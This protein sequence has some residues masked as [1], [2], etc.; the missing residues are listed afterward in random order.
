M[1]YSRRK[2]RQLV[3]G[4]VGIGSNSEVSVQSMTT[5]KTRNTDKTLEQIY[6]LAANGADIVRVTCNEIE[7]AESLVKICTRSPVPIVADIHFQYKLAL[8]AIEAGVQGLRLNPGNIRNEDQIKQ[9]AK[10]CLSAD[11][12]IR[13]GV[14]A[15]SLD[16]DLLEKFGDATPEALV[17]SALNEVKYLEEVNFFN[18]KIS[19]KHSNVPLMI[20]SYRLLAEKVD[21]P[22]HLGVTEAGP[23]PGGLIKSTAGI[24]TLL[25]EGIGD[26]IRMS[27]TTDPIEEAK[28]GR[29]LLEYLGLRERKSLDLIACPSCGRAEVD[30]IKVA[31]EAQAALENEGL[32]IQVAVMGCVVNGPGEARSADIGIAA[33]KKRGHLFIKGEVVKVVD[34]KDMVS[35]LLEEGRLL[36]EEGIEARLAAAD[37]DAALLAQQ[38]AEELMGIQGD[39]N[40]FEERTKSV[41]EITSN[42]DKP[43]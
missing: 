35:A 42:Q 7:A 27:L 12:P 24:A 9:I 5:T 26:T 43:K 16:K 33:G 40:N 20:D 38:D 36:A 23:L 21:Y 22:L 14:N 15:G 41:I 39:I 3:L 19:V 30:V 13:I 32:S 1:T 10:E 28:H 2:T 25:S 18:I 8:A 4:N 17:E 37:K 6:A 11:I 34:E 31:S 29:Q